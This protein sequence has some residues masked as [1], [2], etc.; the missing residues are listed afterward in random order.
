MKQALIVVDYQNDFVTGSLGFPEAAAL[1]QPISQKIEQAREAGADII[2]TYD[3]HDDGY[4]TTQEGKKLPVPH[5]LK[6]SDGWKLDPAIEVLRRPED[7]VFEKGAFGSFEL[8]AFLK[9]KQYGQIELCGVVSNICVISNAVLAKAALPEAE[10][11]VDASCTASNDPVLH[12]K[13]MDVMSGLQI[14]VR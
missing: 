13:A 8:A 6:G 1:R 7:P 10:I 14:I 2:F 3:T 12:Q 9:G 4:S 5:C 11:I